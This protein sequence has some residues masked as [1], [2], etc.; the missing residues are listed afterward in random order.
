M[1]HD[2]AAAALKHV[3]PCF[4]AISPYRIALRLLG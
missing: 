3:P 1:A 2:N 4:Y